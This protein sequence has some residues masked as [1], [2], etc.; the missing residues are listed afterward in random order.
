MSLI[1]AAGSCATTVS[2]CRDAVGTAEWI[3]PLLFPA[4]VV[5]A[6]VAV[7]V[8]VVLRRPRR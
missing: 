2:D 3:P 1:E 8:L 4:V 6:I 5:V 7:F